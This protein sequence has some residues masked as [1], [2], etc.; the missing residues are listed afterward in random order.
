M[1]LQ[2]F[3]A[4]HPSRSHRPGW[5]RTGRG[6][7]LPQPRAHPG[8]GVSS[9]LWVPFWVCRPL[10]ALGPVA[11]W[12]LSKAA[13]FPWSF[14]GLNSVL[15]CPPCS[16][17]ADGSAELLSRIR[18]PALPLSVLIRSRESLWGHFG[19]RS[20][21]PCPGSPRG[22]HSD[23]A[24]PAAPGPGDIRSP[25]GDTRTKASAPGVNKAPGSI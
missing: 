11:L 18:A 12:G 14:W 4:L 6:L 10:P 15:G 17:S 7:C 19:A 9:Q 24:A 21:T 23:P 16:G 8:F 20:P 3:L 13:D 1:P 25:A 5:S 22:S 2:P